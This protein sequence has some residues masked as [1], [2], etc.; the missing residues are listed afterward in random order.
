MASPFRVAILLTEA[1]SLENILPPNSNSLVCLGSWSQEHL[2]AH[3]NKYQLQL[4][5]DVSHTVC[6]GV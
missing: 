2:K 4:I 3:R 5:I 1:D 6:G